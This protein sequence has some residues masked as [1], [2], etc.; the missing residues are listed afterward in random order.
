MMKYQH[1]LQQ[2]VFPV[3]LPDVFREEHLTFEQVHVMF[4]YICPI[5]F[6]V[7]KLHF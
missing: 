4:M 6:G 3:I 1:G 2:E 5:V 7:H